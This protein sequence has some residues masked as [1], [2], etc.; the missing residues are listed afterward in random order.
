VTTSNRRPA[1][2]LLHAQPATVANI[3]S[4]GSLTKGWEQG[5]IIM[6]QK[7]YRLDHDCVAL[8][9]LIIGMGMIA[10]HTARGTLN[11]NPF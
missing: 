10:L 11:G 6:Q 7:L 5:G 3:V 1:V 4:V 8:A 2:G 9:M